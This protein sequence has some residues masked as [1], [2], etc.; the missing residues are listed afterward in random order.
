MEIDEVYLFQQNSHSNGTT[1][2]LEQTT[3]NNHGVELLNNNN[4]EKGNLRHPKQQL[5]NRVMFRNVPKHVLIGCDPT[6][7]QTIQVIDF[8]YGREITLRGR[9]PYHVEYSIKP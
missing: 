3:H 7:K 8:A 2:G 9:L 4:V 5:E 6:L 1:K